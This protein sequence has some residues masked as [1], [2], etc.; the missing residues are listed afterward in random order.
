MIVFRSIAVPIKATLGLPALGRA[1]PSAPSSRCSSG[2]GSTDLLGVRRPG[3]I[4]SFLPIFVMGVLFGLAMDYEMFLV[5]AMR[6]DYVQSGDPARGRR[7][8][9][10]GPR[11]R[12]SRRP[13]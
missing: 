7:C 12:S 6:E 11:R 4:V 13:R 2:A 9:A 10:S 8:A 5:S 1:P 3:P